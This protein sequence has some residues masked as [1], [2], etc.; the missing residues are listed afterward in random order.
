MRKALTVLGWIFLALS[1]GTVALS[2]LGVY[3][4]R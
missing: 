3:L 4:T 2:I 1:T